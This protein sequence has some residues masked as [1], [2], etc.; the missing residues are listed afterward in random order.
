LYN[1]GM[2]RGVKLLLTFILLAAV[3]YVLMHFFKKAMLNEAPSLVSPF[4]G[5]SGPNPPA[6]SPR[7]ALSLDKSGARMTTDTAMPAVQDFLSPAQAADAA[8][9]QAAPVP[10]ADANPAAARPEASRGAEGN[11]PTAQATMANRAA[12][13]SGNIAGKPKAPLSGAAGATALPAAGT[14]LAAGKGSPVSGAVVKSAEKKT[15]DSLLASVLGT[16]ETAEPA[17]IIKPDTASTRMELDAMMESAKMEKADARLAVN[18]PLSA[19]IATEEEKKVVTQWQQTKIV[20]HEESKQKDFA[21]YFNS[22]NYRV[23]GKW[24]MGDSG[25]IVLYKDGTGEVKFKND[26]KKE[27]TLRGNFFFRYSIS[28]NIINLI[29]ILTKESRRRITC[30]YILK[31]KDN[32]ITIGSFHYKSSEIN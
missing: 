25:S 11:L 12:S 22:L 7:P 18:V 1:D 9:R 20:E 10:A 5:Q 28:G 23:I 16:S 6:P 8:S 2:G 4:S 13:S 26:D 3:L 30:H 17:P 29:P 14:A 15:E 21:H 31:L 27:E 32:G 19:Q 24:A